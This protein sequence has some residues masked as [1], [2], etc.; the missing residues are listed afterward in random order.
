[1]AGNPH[2][3]ILDNPL[4]WWVVTGC[5]QIAV[6]ALVVTLPVPHGGIAIRP[7]GPMAALALAAVLVALV[8]R[9]R[10]PVAFLV[11]ATGASALARI[12]EPFPIFGFQL[13]M[14]MAMFSVAVAV[15]LLHAALLTMGSFGVWF[16]VSALV[17]WPYVVTYDILA[18]CGL[19]VA[20]TVTG[21]MVRTR[22]ALTEAT[23]QREIEADRA[24]E[25]LARQTLAE[26]RL[27]MAREL[28]DSVGHG[29]VTMSLYAQAAAKSV[30]QHPE[31]ALRSLR[32]VQ[33]TASTLVEDLGDM[34]R[35]LRGEAPAAGGAGKNL[36]DLGD[37]VRDAGDLGMNVNLRVLGHDVGANR[38]VSHVAY[39][40]AKEGLVNARKHGS[41]RHPVEVMVRY[42]PDSV[43]VIV[44]N[45]LTR[46]STRGLP[47]TSMSM[48][49]GLVGMSERAESVG[50]RVVAERRGLTFVVEA[51]LP[52]A[53]WAA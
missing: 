13:A 14:L 40:I 46:T 5:A 2:G 17:G 25:A 49:Q 53:G 20:V 27:D 21:Q 32:V 48:G 36:D 23:A 16:A 8:A 19:T 39:R 42:R 18:I 31:A 37:L 28:H 9:S 10:F 50:G 43:D 1:M 4:G 7:P 12:E 15:P 34:L 52:L 51:H 45:R 6:V 22:V 38:E 3:M 24:K 11:V 35:D 30:R 26:Q 44:R 29:I 47:R 33:D 41:A